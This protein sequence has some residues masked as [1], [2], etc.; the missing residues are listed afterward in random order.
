VLDEAKGMTVEWKEGDWASGSLPRYVTVE[1]AR[2]VTVVPR[3]KPGDEG[4]PFICH[5]VNR[6]YVLESDSMAVQRNFALILA[7]SLFGGG[8]ASATLYA[9]R[10]SPV[11]LSVDRAGDATRIVVPELDLWAVLKLE[12]A[13]AN[14]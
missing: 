6:N 13:G 14:R 10:K 11:A 9:P 5:L 3:S 12:P 8:I 7:D 1:G 4:A 2:N